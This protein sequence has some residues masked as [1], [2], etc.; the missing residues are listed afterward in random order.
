MVYMKSRR[1]YGDGLGRSDLA[2]VKYFADLICFQNQLCREILLNI[3]GVL[4]VRIRKIFVVG[5]FGD[6]VFV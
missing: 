1:F 4:G 2:C 6:V 3:K 5:V